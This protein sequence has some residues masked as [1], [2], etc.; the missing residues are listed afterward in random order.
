MATA[1]SRSIVR[2]LAMPGQY[3]VFHPGRARV[4]DLTTVCFNL[5][6]SGL[7]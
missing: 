2:Y 6:G 4:A 5:S 7:S 3:R 1:E